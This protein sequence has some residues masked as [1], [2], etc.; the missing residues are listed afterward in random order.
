MVIHV[1]TREKPRAIVR[2]MKT[3]QDEGV[4]VVRRALPFGD[5]SSPSAPGI[6]I[7]RK[8]N[9]NEVASNLVQDRCRFLREVERANR[10]GTLLIVLVEHSNRIKT[11]EDVIQW[12][13]PRLKQSP[14]AVSGERLYRIMHNTA[15]RYGFRWAFCDKVH[16]GKVIIKMLGGDYNA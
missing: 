14:L 15:D 9:L 12:K 11:L 10:A 16:T 5:Y 6:V 2:I 8:Q 1:D 13:N 7:D 4:E 3:F